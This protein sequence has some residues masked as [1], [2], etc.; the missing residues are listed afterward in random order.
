MLPW[1]PRTAVEGSTTPR[2]HQGN[3]Q[4][5]PLFNY[6]YSFETHTKKATILGNPHVTLRGVTWVL[7]SVT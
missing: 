5:T 6:Y 1:Y 7:P 4:V 3:P 2:K